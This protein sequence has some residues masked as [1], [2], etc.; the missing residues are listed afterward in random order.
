MNRLLLATIF[1]MIFIIIIQ[2]DDKRIG[3]KIPRS[4]YQ[5]SNEEEGDDEGKMKK[6]LLIDYQL[7]KQNNL[8]NENLV[9]E[10]G[11]AAGVERGVKCFSLLIE[12]FTK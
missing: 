5:G 8:A 1:L 9:E 6:D 12:V 11:G 3:K 7:R 2:S 4:I 10:G